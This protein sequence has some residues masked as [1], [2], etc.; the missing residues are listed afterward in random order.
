MNEIQESRPGAP[1]GFGVVAVVSAV[2]MVGLAAAC[3]SHV[4]SPA[5]PSTWVGATALSGSEDFPFGVVVAGANV[6]YT[7]GLSQA[8]DHAVRVAPLEPA[9]PAASRILIDSPFPNGALAVD[10]DDV[11]VAAGAGIVRVSITNGSITPVVDGRPTTVTSVA[12]DDR[13]L[14]WTASTYKFGAAAEVAR[15]AKAGGAVEMLAAG[16]DEKGH[17]YQD[18]PARQAVAVAKATSFNSVLPDGDSAV[19]AS[20]YAILRVAAG[21]K[22]VVVVSS[23]VLGGP[24]DHLVAGGQRIYGETAGNR[25]N[26]FALPRAGGVPVALASGADDSRQIAVAGGELLFFTAGS[27]GG[28]AR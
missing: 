2:A 20:P 4:S 1:F 12:V 3:G 25:K 18:D 14:W 27:F 15:V 7:T 28:K 8:G 16:V 21:Q 23:D 11:Y 9:T 10:G 24:P 19:V 5:A 17:V 13:Y 6:L 22:P 26:L